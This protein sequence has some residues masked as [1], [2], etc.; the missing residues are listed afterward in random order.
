MV[1]AVEKNDGKYPELRLGRKS[2]R[3]EFPSKRNWTVEVHHAG[4]VL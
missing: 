3:T 1:A 4:M 2:V